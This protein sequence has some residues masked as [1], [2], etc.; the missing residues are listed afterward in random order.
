MRWFENIFFV[1]KNHTQK[2]RTQ[3]PTTYDV[4][5]LYKSIDTI[6][7]KYVYTDAF[8]FLR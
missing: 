2:I 3:V 1:D 5:I 8:K 4:L 7:L 6:F